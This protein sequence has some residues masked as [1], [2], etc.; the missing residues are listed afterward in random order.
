MAAI[1]VNQAT[2]TLSRPAF[3]KSA[4]LIVVGSLLAQIL[5]SYLQ[6]N[7][8]DIPVTGADALYPLVAAFLS[9]AVLPG[10]YGRNIALGSAATSVRVAAD[11]FGL[12]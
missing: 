5:T 8:Y 4:V 9:M 11:Q 3:I 6:D 7:V 12:I 2:R 10:G 1:N